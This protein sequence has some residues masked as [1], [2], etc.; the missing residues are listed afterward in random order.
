[1]AGEIDFLRDLGAKSELILK[2]GEARLRCHGSDA[3]FQQAQCGQKVE[4][5][6]DAERCSVFAN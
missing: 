6:F 1:M 4:I 5:L 3:L 2:C